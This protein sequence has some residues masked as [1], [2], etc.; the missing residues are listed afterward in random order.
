[1]TKTRTAEKSR[2]NLAPVDVEDKGTTLW[3]VSKDG[4]DISCLVR[5]VPY[6]IEIDLLRDGRLTVTRTFETDDEALAWARR[7]RTEREAEGWAAQD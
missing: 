6:G 1:M 5:L 7:K 2:S 4:R 3:T